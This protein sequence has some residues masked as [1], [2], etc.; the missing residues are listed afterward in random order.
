MEHHAGDAIERMLRDKE[1]AAS[2]KLVH[3]T[4]F[5]DELAA[6][7]DDVAFEGDQSIYRTLCYALLSMLH[8]C[9][10]TCQELQWHT[11]TLCASA[12]DWPCLGFTINVKLCI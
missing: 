1:E 4:S 12:S 9:E 2:R 10:R 3:D 11:L 5:L 7:A 6:A 8:L